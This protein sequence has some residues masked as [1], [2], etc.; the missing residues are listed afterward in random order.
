MIDHGVIFDAPLG[1]SGFQVRARGISALAAASGTSGPLDSP[2][3]HVSA[4]RHATA[5][6]CRSWQ[7]N[8]MQFKSEPVPMG[9]PYI[10]PG[11]EGSSV[12][13]FLGAGNSTKYPGTALYTE[14]R[15]LMNIGSDE[16]EKSPN[17]RCD[18]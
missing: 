12:N 4:V 5:R 14:E 17:V 3:D 9:A 10:F 7:M 1:S 13:P 6:R 2:A 18:L 11:A 15:T 16:S 8:H